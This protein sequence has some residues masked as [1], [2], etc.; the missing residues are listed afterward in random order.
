MA[1][2]NAQ[3]EQEISLLTSA[4]NDFTGNQK[5]ESD[6]PNITELDSTEYIITY[7]DGIF[8]KFLSRP[9]DSSS[10]LKFDSKLV[11][12]VHGTLSARLSGNFSFDDSNAIEETTIKV[13]WTGDATPIISNSSTTWIRN[14]I[15]EDSNYLI[16]LNYDSLDIIYGSIVKVGGSTTNTGGDTTPPNQITDLSLTDLNSSGGDTTPP[17]QITDLSLTDLNI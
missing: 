5:I 8:K 16:L 4:L 15:D 3:L 10:I 13:H 9:T 2:S 6:L 11:T 14:D 17:T 7:Q 1:K 12:T